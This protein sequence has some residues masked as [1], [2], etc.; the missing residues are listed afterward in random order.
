ME[1][2]PAIL[3][4]TCQYLEGIRSE[5]FASLVRYRT[6]PSRD[7]MRPCGVPAEIMQQRAGRIQRLWNVYSR[8]N[9]SRAG[10][11]IRRPGDYPETREHVLPRST[12][13]DPVS[14]LSMH[15]EP[16][17]RHISTAALRLSMSL[18]AGNELTCVEDFHKQGGA[19]RS[20]R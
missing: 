19:C 12:V 15:I 17:R 9:R 16:R 6:D 20:D 10:V 3:V 1:R 18:L 7:A 11:F 5:A 14:E 8:E 13:H 2:Q 4:S